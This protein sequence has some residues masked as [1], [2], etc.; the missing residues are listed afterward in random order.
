MTSAA[1]L[2]GSVVFHQSI[3]PLEMKS[4]I[5]PFRLVYF[6]PKE[7]AYKTLTTEPIALQMSP[8]TSAERSRTSRHPDA[9][10]SLSSA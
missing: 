2:S 1:R 7:D 10:P 3:R 9:S 6:D 8:N 4:E 5:P